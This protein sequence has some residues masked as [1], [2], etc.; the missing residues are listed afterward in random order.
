VLRVA[1]SRVLLELSAGVTLFGLVHHPGQLLENP[2]RR[3]HLVEH[4]PT[5]DVLALGSFLY[6]LLEGSRTEFDLLGTRVL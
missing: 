6:P 5:R 4:L 2:V 1:A 3:E